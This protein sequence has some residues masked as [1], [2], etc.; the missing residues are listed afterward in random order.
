MHRCP[1]LK[2]TCMRIP[3]G[4][5][6]IRW[7]E[8]GGVSRPLSCPVSQPS[9]VSGSSGQ[10]VTFKNGQIGWA[11][12]QGPNLVLATYQ[13]DTDVAVEW[14]PTDPCRYDKF[15]VVW[16]KDGQ[17]ITQ[18]EVDRPIALAGPF[19]RGID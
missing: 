2:N 3:N 11:P 14:V 17:M 5:I 9:N 10:V 16:N 19:N 6:K 15:N 13:V 4:L 7:E 12:E 18:N 1:V 8:L